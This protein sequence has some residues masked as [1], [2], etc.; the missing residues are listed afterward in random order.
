[1]I[2]KIV[3]VSRGSGLI[4]RCPEC[5]RYVL[6][7]QC[8]DHGKVMGINDLRV[9]AKLNDGKVTY[10]LLL[11]CKITEGLMDFTLD[12]ALKLGEEA[13][14]TKINEALE[15]KSFEVKGDRLETN[16]L[17]KGIRRI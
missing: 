8:K 12:A 11:N 3:R 14:L 2:G 1:M 17:V 9:K 6:D 10:N 7:N 16:F 5:N 4:Q 15:G 13:V